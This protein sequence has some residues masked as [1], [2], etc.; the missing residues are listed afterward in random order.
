LG[1]ES[2]K[3][4][5]ELVF[6]DRMALTRGRQREAIFTCKHGFF[7]FRLRKIVVILLAFDHSGKNATQ[8]PEID[9]GLVFTLQEYDL[10]RSEE[11]G[12]HVV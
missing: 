1:T 8:A 12:D 6:F 7:P 2:L 10:G 9:R 5:L 3:D 11:S 4:D